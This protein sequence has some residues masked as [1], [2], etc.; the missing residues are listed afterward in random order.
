MFLVFLL[1][2]AGSI[3]SIPTFF[4][5]FLQMDKLTKKINSYQTDCVMH[6]KISSYFV[7]FFLY[8]SSIFMLMMPMYLSNWPSNF[9][10]DA[11]YQLKEVLSNAYT[12]HH[13]LLHTW[14]MGFFYNYGDIK[15]AD[16]SKGFALYTLFQIVILSFSFAYCMLY[17]YKKD[18]PKKFRIITYIFFAVLPLNSIFAITATKDILFAAFFLLFLTLLLELFDINDSDLFIKNKTLCFLL[19]GLLVSGILM[20]LFR[21][22]AKFAFILMIPL[23]FFISKKWKKKF[24]FLLALLIILIGSSIINTSMINTFNAVDRDSRRETLSVPLQQLARVASYKKDSLDPDLYQEIIVYINES[25]LPSYSPYLS[26]PIKNDAN[27]ELLKSNITN[28]FKLWAK[29]GLKYPDEYVDS[30]LTNTMGL[31]YLGDSNY[32]YVFDIA[33]Y[34]QLIDGSNIQQIEKKDYFPLSFVSNLFQ[35]LFTYL[36]FRNIPLYSYLFNPSLYTW[37][38]F[39]SFL[40]SFYKRQYRKMIPF[41]LMILYLASCFFAPTVML[42][43]IYCLI[44]SIP[45]LIILLFIPQKRST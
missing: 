8:W 27:E 22:N 5:L 7:R 44:V 9:I 11:K 25:K 31:W 18:V 19:L 43:Y 33:T 40:Y 17:L 45:L 12:T 15:F 24:M 38:I 28:F 13:P 23:F 42:R 37:I 32:R 30:F 29:V 26:D 39:I 14:L 1:V 21:N 34:H 35:W 16:V 41:S 20:I 2:L 3:I 6:H 4:C 36:N 10:F